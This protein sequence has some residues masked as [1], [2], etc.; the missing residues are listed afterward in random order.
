MSLGNYGDVAALVTQAYRTPAV[1]VV[2]PVAPARKPVERTCIFRLVKGATFQDEAARRFSRGKKRKLTR[3][4]DLAIRDAAL[5]LHDERETEVT[6]RMILFE[7]QPHQP[8]STSTIS[9]RLRVDFKMPWGGV[10]R[11]LQLSPEDVLSRFAF[12]QL[13]RLLPREFWIRGCCF[14]DCKVWPCY[15]TGAAR[16]HALHAAVRG[17]YKQRGNCK[18][19]PAPI[20]KAK[21]HKHKHRHGTGHKSIMVCAGFGMGQCLFAVHVAQG[22]AWQATEYVNVVNQQLALLPLDPTGQKLTVIRDRDP[23][24]FHTGLGKQAEQHHAV[25]VLEI[26]CRTPG[27]MPLDY[28]FHTAVRRNLR[29]TEAGFGPAYTEPRPL[30]IQR[31]LQA[32]HAVPP[33]Q[34]DAGCGDMV[35]RLQALF[36][37]KG[38]DGWRD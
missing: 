20:R 5:R 32:Y 19:G 38:D 28:T 25:P 17:M 11:R 35:R 2:G 13:Y 6:A 22:V 3:D 24:G 1:P 12:A 9:R 31:L 23:K 4:E 36:D 10:P 29:A 8:V 37:C 30:Y 34:V 7:V 21:P 15:S 18:T 27:L 26:P 14:I 33:P 16:Q